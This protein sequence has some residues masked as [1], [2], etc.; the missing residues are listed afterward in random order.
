MLQLVHHEKIKSNR[1][2]KDRI[3]KKQGQACKFLL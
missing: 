1:N 2:L 3:F